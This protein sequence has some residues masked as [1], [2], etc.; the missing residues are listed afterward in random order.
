[1]ES[2]KAEVRLTSLC[3]KLGYLWSVNDIIDLEDIDTVEQEIECHLVLIVQLY[4]TPINFPAFQNAMKRA[5]CNDSVEI[6]QLEHGLFQF[7]FKSKGD[8]WQVLDCA[9]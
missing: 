6:L 8:K 5:R 4:T 9:P 2:M 7:V 3:K 1:M